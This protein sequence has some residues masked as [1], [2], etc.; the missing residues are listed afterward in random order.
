MSIQP[1]GHRDIGPPY[2]DN[3]ISG[4]EPGILI[5]LGIDRRQQPLL[6]IEFS[7]TTRMSAIQSGRFVFDAEPPFFNNAVLATH[8]DSVLAFLTGRR[9]A[10][11]RAT[12]DVKG[13]VGLL[14]GRPLQGTTHI[15]DATGRVALVAGTDVVLPLASRVA[16]VPFARYMYAV[17]GDESMSVALGSH[18][19]R[20]GAALRVA[21]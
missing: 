5:A 9:L 6:T 2:L 3:P 16:V 1:R 7:T 18:I 8:R 19:I 14:F 11:G 17:R 4:V 21:F 10:M 20:V 13:G 12:L 15:D